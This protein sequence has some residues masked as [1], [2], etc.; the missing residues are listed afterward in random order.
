MARWA[1]SIPWDQDIDGYLSKTMQAD[2]TSNDPYSI[3]RNTAEQRM[4]PL[5][6]LNPEETALCRAALGAMRG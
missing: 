1:P 2:A 4:R 3:M 5:K 6:F